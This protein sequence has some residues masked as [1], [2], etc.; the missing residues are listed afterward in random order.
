MDGYGLGLALLAER[1]WKEFFRS[2]CGAYF[3]CQNLHTHW[4]GEYSKK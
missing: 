2:S 4:S 1:K 3:M